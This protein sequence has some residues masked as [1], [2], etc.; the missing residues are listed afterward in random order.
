[1]PHVRC[2]AQLERTG[3]RRQAP[4]SIGAVLDLK[5]YGAHRRAAI[6]PAAT[7]GP[8]ACNGDARGSCRHGN[9]PAPVKCLSQWA[10][11]RCGG[12]FGSRVASS[13]P[14]HMRCAM[15]RPSGSQPKMMPRTACPTSW[16]ASTGHRRRGGR[17]MAGPAKCGRSAG[18]GAARA[19]RRWRRST[20][21]TLLRGW[22]CL[23]LANQGAFDVGTHKPGQPCIS[24]IAAQ[25]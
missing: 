13:G 1:M 2:H 3:I 21:A 22:S 19:R 9:V 12:P 11:E 6:A 24:F 8:G 4:P 20:R 17:A 25:K 15:V 5:N 18:T 10:G 7:T 23:A 14:P 16:C